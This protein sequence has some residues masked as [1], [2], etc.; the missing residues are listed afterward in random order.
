MSTPSGVSTPSRASASNVCGHG[1]C[2]LQLARTLDSHCVVSSLPR[3]PEKN[4]TAGPMLVEGTS[5]GKHSVAEARP[6]RHII[7]I[8]SSLVVAAIA[9]IGVRVFVFVPCARSGGC[10]CD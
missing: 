3:A 8:G 9:T 6:N 5:S 2:P 10:N 1:H 7:S 4:P